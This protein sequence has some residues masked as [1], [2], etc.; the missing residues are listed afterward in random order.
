[1]TIVDSE[2]PGP[3]AMIGAPVH[4]NEIC[5]AFRNTGHCRYGEECKFIHSEGEPIAP[6]LTTTS[7]WQRIVV[8]LPPVPKQARSHAL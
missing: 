2:T 7:L 5:R 1:M 6:P 4:G 8:R 3:T